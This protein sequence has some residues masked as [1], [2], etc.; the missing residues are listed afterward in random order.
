VTDPLVR[1]QSLWNAINNDASCNGNT[2]AP[3]PK[4]EFKQATLT[5]T[6]KKFSL[7]VAAAYDC[8]GIGAGW[9]DENYT[10]TK[11]DVDEYLTSWCSCGEANWEKTH[12]RTVV[13]ETIVWSDAN[14]GTDSSR[15]ITLDTFTV[16]YGSYYNVPAS[17][18]GHIPYAPN[19]TLPNP[20]CVSCPKDCGPGPG[21][22]G[23]H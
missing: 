9:N 18:T 16:G 5:K 10:E 11:T 13:H 21:P 20:C 1:L 22:G 8:F 6:I 4:H 23:S 7:S 19:V 2:I 15:D 14:C 17:W 12:T 3:A